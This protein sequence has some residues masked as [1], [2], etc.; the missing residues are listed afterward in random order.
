MM[1]GRRAAHA[2]TEALRDNR[3]NRDGVKNYIDWW[4]KNFPGFMDY[5]EFLTLMTSGLA[6]ED[7]ANY[8]Y[9]L[10]TETLPCSLNPYNLIKNINGSIMGKIGT[11]QQERPDIIAMM[12]TVATIPVE[13]QMKVFAVTGFP[14]Y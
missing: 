7:I 5:R 8:L 2:I 9:K 11:I 4:Q 13:K 3:P 6:G 12:Q 10:V 14:N 1:T